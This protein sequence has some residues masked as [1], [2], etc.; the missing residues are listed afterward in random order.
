MN[1]Q[2][3]KG[4]FLIVASMFYLLAL[5]YVWFAKGLY[6]PWLLKN[7]PTDLS[8]NKL[9][10]FFKGSDIGAYCS[11][12]RD[13][14]IQGKSAFAKNIGE[15][16]FWP[17]GQFV[18]YSIGSIISGA[19]SSIFYYFFVHIVLLW[20]LVFVSVGHFASRFFG[21]RGYLFPLAFMFLPEFNSFL[22]KVGLYGSDGYG[23]ATF[24]IAFSFLLFNKELTFRNSLFFGLV[25]SISAYYRSVNETLLLLMTF[26]YVFSLL[27]KALQ[28]KVKRRMTL[29]NS[30]ILVHRKNKF[31]L[32]C[33]LFAV[34]LT[35]PWRVFTYK[36]EK[37][38]AWTRN[39][40]FEI[41]SSWYNPEDSA[42]WFLASGGALACKLD[43]VTCSAYH[44]KGLQHVKKT[45]KFKSLLKVIVNHPVS[46]FY[47]KV[48][49][50]VKQWLTPYYLEQNILLDAYRAFLLIIF[51]T[52]PIL[53]FKNFILS[54]DTSLKRVVL[55]G[56]CFGMSMIMIMIVHI[57]P[58][59]L[60]M[61]KLLS[62]IYVLDML[63]ES[64]RFKIFSSKT[65]YNV[66]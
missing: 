25:I 57:E 4:N 6:S 52:Y 41:H 58:R 42:P 30:L 66:C 19:Q 12:G 62:I 60:Y 26:M 5:L 63:A 8:I 40:D 48:S 11:V 37:R 31:L 44:I 47:V 23:I 56:S 49:V 2:V 64:K 3:K 65:A 1:E 14:S 21:V 28:L 32:Y 34:I 13:L 53:I 22:L 7:I 59:Y 20:L 39:I 38:I 61:N 24:L 17:P 9:C 54:H 16:S 55:F 29:A 15:F 18:N 10:E 35:V 27:Y 43:P 46:W 33:L 50:F 36:V 45:D 51:F